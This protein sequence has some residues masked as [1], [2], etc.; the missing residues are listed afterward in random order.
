MGEAVEEALARRGGRWVEAGAPD[1]PDLGGLENPPKRFCVRGSFCGAGRGPHRPAVAVIG[2]R[3]VDPAALELA[4]RFGFALARAGLTVVSGGALGVD[5]AAHEGALAAGGR[6]VAVLPSGVLRPHPP[7]NRALFARILAAGGGLCSE[8][9]A[10]A[11]PIPW[12]IPERNRLIAALSRAVVVVRAAR[13]T[14][15]AHTVKA[16][17]RLGRPIYAVPPPAELAARWGYCADLLGG[18]CEDAVALPVRD[19][20]DLLEALGVGAGRHDVGALGREERLVVGALAGRAA[21][22]G[23]I[24]A[25]AGLSLGATARILAALCTRGLAAPAGP[26]R[27]AAVEAAGPALHPGA[28]PARSDPP[29]SDASDRG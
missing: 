9:E 19:P 18:L 3:R 14:G 21:S 27:F 20:D 29:R 2:A 13:R 23:A 28:R 10:D 8:L 17:H 16:A 6:T 11:R 4:R 15:C 26:G 5:A 25:A 24:A 7:R 22:L 12:Q 1:Y